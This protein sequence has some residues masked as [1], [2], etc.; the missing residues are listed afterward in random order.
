ME[1]LAAE[2]LNA[3][4]LVIVL[5]EHAGDDVI[6]ILDVF[7]LLYEKDFE[8]AVGNIH[9]FLRNIKG[10]GKRCGIQSGAVNVI[11]LINVALIIRDLQISGAQLQNNRKCSGEI[12]SMSEPVFHFLGGAVGKRS[13]RSNRGDISEIA[14][15]HFSEIAGMCFSFHDVDRGF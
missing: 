9:I 2:E 14:V 12:G 5:S 6:E 1:A 7:W 13:Q 3:V 4:T 8:D 10:T 11:S 15:M